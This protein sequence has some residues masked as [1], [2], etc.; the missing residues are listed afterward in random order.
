[1][2]TP[3]YP[4]DPQWQG[5]QDPNYPTQPGYPPQQGYPPQPSYPQRPNYPQ[6]AYPSQPLY[7]Q[8]GEQQPGYPPQ[9]GFGYGGP[10]S[11]YPGQPPYG[12][13]PQPPNRVPLIIGIVAAVVLLCV[14][15]PGAFIVISA[16]RIGTNAQRI[17]ANVEATMTAQAELGTPTSSPDLTIYEN[18]MDGTQIDWSNNDHCAFKADGYHIIGNFICFAPPSDV[19]D[20]TITV[21]VKQLTGVSNKFHGI[22]F[23]R[24]SKGNYYAFEID[25]NGSWSFFAVKN[26]TPVSIVDVTQNP[27]IV[28]G[29]S[30]M[31]TMQ[32]SAVGSHF[33]FSVNG[34]PVGQADDTSFT[35]GLMGLDGD[36]GA[37]V[38]YT[39]FKA[40]QP[41]A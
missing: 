11:Q 23:R 30:V 29:L 22:V 6:P 36:D 7:P 14:V 21:M 27:A 1:V 2:S 3:Q 33:V 35:S 28:K 8:H 26:D 34:T 31:N 5:G 39:N 9:Q 37:D 19:S 16:M 38:A 32:V 10:P 20:A 25:A 12:G 17:A 13:P 18:P 24:A 15:L 41:S 4:I 40:T